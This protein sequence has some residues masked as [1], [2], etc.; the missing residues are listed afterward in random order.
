[1][2]SPRHP[3]IGLIVFVVACFAVA[4][5]GSI[6]TTPKLDNWYA[7]LV[8]PGWNPPNWIFGPVW[9][10]LYLTM[11]VAAWLIWRQDGLD[12][13]RWSLTLFGVQLGLNLLWS[14]IFFGMKNP[15]LAFGEVLLLWATIVATMVAFWRRSRIAGLLF[16]P[17]L[18]WVTFAAVLNYTIWRLNA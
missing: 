16:V 7:A 14:W 3:W 2:T 10:A 15:G 5:L 4:W 12:E 18:A 8:K 1:M 9:S 17:Y 13:A 11:A 6:A